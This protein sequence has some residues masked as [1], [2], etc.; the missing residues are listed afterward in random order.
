MKYNRNLLLYTITVL[1]TLTL[2]E[3][4]LQILCLLSPSVNFLLSP[5]QWQYHLYD[6][7]RV[8]KP[9]PNHPEH[10]EKGYRNRF[11]PPKATI[12]ALGDSQTYGSFVSQDEPWPQQL[13]Q[14]SNITTYNMAVQGYSPA[15]SLLMFDEVVEMKPKLIIEA[16]YAGNDLYDSHQLVY[17]YSKL[18]GLKTTDKALLKSLRDL[19]DTDTI[20][21]KSWAYFHCTNKT[22]TQPHG[23]V[24]NF[25]AH[26]SK[27]YGLLRAINAVYLN[28]FT[29]DPLESLHKAAV[30]EYCTLYDNGRIKTAFKTHYRLLTLN[31]SDPRIAEGHRISLEAIRLMN[32]RAKAEDI[33][34]IVL[35]LPTKEIVFRDVVHEGT[36][37][38]S[39][40]FLALL[41]NEEKY[42][43]KNREFFREHGIHFIDAIPALRASLL[44]G[45]QPYPES[46]DAHPNPVG[47]QVIAELVY[48]EIKKQHL[49]EE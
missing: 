4:I 2:M 24:R 35:L 13:E 46:W 8:F 3:L 11:I 41:E 39:E 19:E 14:T 29:P 34:F 12:I 26:H 38:A 33:G 17:I 5:V 21:E 47:H 27:I 45:S 37:N 30:N 49:L 16:F 48:S 40:T 15:Y 22:K 42:L 44:N 43:Q 18:E 10:D 31:L 9:N 36:A 23:P 7:R 32:E 6:E 28:Y 1:V 20:E 25:F